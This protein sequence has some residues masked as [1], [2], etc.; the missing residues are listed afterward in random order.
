[1]DY[2]GLFHD[3]AKPQ[4]FT[5][6]RLYRGKREREDSRKKEPITD[7]D[8]MKTEKGDWKCGVWSKL[9]EIHLF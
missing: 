5:Y 3:L 4:R 9:V 2:E 6:H 7:H 8:A 1:V